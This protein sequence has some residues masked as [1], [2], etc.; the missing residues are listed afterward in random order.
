[1]KCTFSLFCSLVLACVPIESRAIYL[2]GIE[3]DSG[4]LYRISTTDASLSL[5]GATGLGGVG[6][7][8]FAPDGRLLAFTTGPDAALYQID[9]N[10]AAATLIGALNIGFVSEGGMAFGPDGTA[11]A[12][13]LASVIPTGMFKIDTNTGQATEIAPLGTGLH[14]VNGLAWRS[15]G[16]LV[17]LDR[18]S[19][20]LILIDPVT[21]AISTLAPLAPTVGSVGDMT[22][23]ADQGYFTTAGPA[24]TYPGS[25][26][27]YAF[28]ALTGDYSLVGSFAS[29]ING[30][31]ISAL[32]MIPEP[33][34][35]MLSMLALA[36][37]AIL[38]RRQTQLQAS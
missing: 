13:E 18:G 29:T 5:V 38:A 3:W 9:P 14:D 27:L 26:S 19:N 23:M 30:T 32:A 31:G 22:D 8:S 17:G 20:M 10:T 1:M 15:D 21:G 36:F 11:Y 7:M 37:W 35:A 6:G 2:Y 25:N 12:V 24:G 28:N 34:G 4:S 16:K 33:P